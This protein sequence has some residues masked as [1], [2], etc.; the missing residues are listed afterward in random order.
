MQRFVIGLFLLTA[1]LA[2]GCA[3]V[4][5]GT[6]DTLI[7]NSDPTGALV[8]LSNGL[9]GKTPATF[10]LP[11]K[12]TLVV[13]ISKEGYEPVDVNVT[14]QIAGA[15]SA[16]MVGNVFLGGIIGAAVDTGTGAMY[17]L[18]PNPI[19]VKLVPLARA[20]P[21]P[22]PAV[23]KPKQSVQQRLAKL[24]SMRDAGEISQ[25]EYEKLSLRIIDEH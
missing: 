10:K 5:R 22:P 3:S 23:V 15:G 25:E 9:M 1:I 20:K 13:K 6:S 8:E 12:S 17:D 21:A 16:G 18:K 19:S 14:P 11:R 24:K 7:V 4:T 2:S